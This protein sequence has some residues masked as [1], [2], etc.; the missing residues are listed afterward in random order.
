VRAFK[1]SPKF[2]GYAQATRDL[3]GRE[4][5][6]AARPRLPWRLSRHEI[7]PSLVQAYF[8]GLTGLPGKQ[9]AALAALKQLEKWAVVR[10]LLPRQITLG[11]ETEDSDGGHIPWTAD[12]VAFAEA[13]LPAHLSRAVTLAANTGQRGSD[14]IRMG[15]T[16]IETYEGIEGISIR[17]KK[18]KRDVWV[19]IAS[20]LAAALRTWER[21][22]GPFL[23][24]ASGPPVDPQGADRGVDL[25][26]GEQPCIRLL[27][28]LRAGY[29]SADGSARPPRSRLR[30][31]AA[32]RGEHPPDFRHGGDERGDGSELHPVLAAAR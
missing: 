15:W 27:P 30:G 29:G 23:R 17:Q 21:Q 31:A 6:Y 4:L 3:W 22:P 28:P 18:T 12:Q 25:P 9:A 7:K 2:N 26:A 13:N 8:D 5:D 10:D 24:R 32:R 14:L 1:V 16:D 11:V 20:P 19:P